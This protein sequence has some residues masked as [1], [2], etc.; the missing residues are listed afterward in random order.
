MAVPSLFLVLTAYFLHAAAV[1]DR[2]LRAA[3]ERQRDL[4]AAQDALIRAEAERGVWE[5]R[6]AGLRAN[7]L[8]T[9][10]VEERA[11]AML[12]LSHPDDIVVPL[13]DAPLR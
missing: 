3:A 7:R 9:D 8:D 11:R 6:V 10:A 5:R 13:P 1:G 12:G 2:G 4:L